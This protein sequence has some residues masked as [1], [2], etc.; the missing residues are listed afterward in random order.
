MLRKENPEYL[1]EKVRVNAL[2]QAAAVAQLPRALG[3]Q[4]WET[5]VD[6]RA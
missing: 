2:G 3:R 1:H 4:H 6:P 5:N